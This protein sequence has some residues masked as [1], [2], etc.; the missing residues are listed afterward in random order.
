MRIDLLNV[1]QVLP[2]FL[3]LHVLLV[4]LDG[5]HVNTAVVPVFIHLASLVG[6]VVVVI[7]ADLSDP[8]ALGVVL[9]V[10]VEDD[11]DTCGVVETL[12]GTHG[13]VLLL[14]LDICTIV[15]NLLGEAEELGEV[16]VGDG[17]EDLLDVLLALGI[18]DAVGLDGCKDLICGATEHVRRLVAQGLLK[19]VQEV[20]VYCL[21]GL[22][23]RTVDLH[24][25]DIGTQDGLTLLNVHLGLLLHNRVA[26]TLPLL[27][28]LPLLLLQLLELLG[29]VVLDHVAH[30]LVHPPAQRFRLSCR[31][32][33]GR[34]GTFAL[35]HQV[36]IR[37]VL[38]TLE[39]GKL[40]R[41]LRCLV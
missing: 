2:L 8:G 30:L 5:R 23:A 38:E 22:R 7:L 25:G 15:R 14:I 4:F 18:E 6:R 12:L 31:F 10:L 34:S 29:L 28:L 17:A 13:I 36:G 27:G 40:L 9:V 19:P 16:L 24:L 41:H 39:L 32:I 26:A 21:G 33:L 35:Q 3:V 37:T 20:L 1:D 11:G